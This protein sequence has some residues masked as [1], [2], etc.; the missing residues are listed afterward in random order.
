M[1]ASPELLK[2]MSSIIADHTMPEPKYI[3][4]NNTGQVI[5]PSKGVM[6]ALTTLKK[7]DV[8]QRIDEYMN[9]K[10]FRELGTYDQELVTTMREEYRN[11]ID[12]QLARDLQQE[13]YQLERDRREEEQRK[14]ELGRLQADLLE[15]QELLLGFDKA[16]ADNQLKIEKKGPL[17]E[18]ARLYQALKTSA[19]GV[20][21]MLDSIKA[22]YREATGNE[23]TMD[24]L[25]QLPEMYGPDILDKYT[26]YMKTMETINLLQRQLQP[27]VTDFTQ[28]LEQQINN[29]FRVIEAN[30][31]RLM[32]QRSELLQFISDIQNKIASLGSRSS[33]RGDVGGGKRRRKR[34]RQRRRR[35]A[36]RK[37]RLRTNKRCK[38]QSK[39]QRKK[40]SK[41]QRNKQRNKQRKKQRKKLSSRR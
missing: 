30:Q 29:Y 5:R 26:S 39:K 16:I 22:D 24:N 35:T 14:K 13:E 8:L 11:E 10:N 36:K 27:Y 40:Q 12:Q 32:K 7:T 19:T 41:K 37:T 34:T 17:L 3:I 31:Q 21:E 23:L 18:N 4:K 25:R 15:S 38:K 9:T 2:Q 33:V 20:E 1:E 28:P 6:Q